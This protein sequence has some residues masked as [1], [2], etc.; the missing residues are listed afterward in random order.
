MSTALDASSPT[1]HLIYGPTAAGKST[2]ARQLAAKVNGVRFAIDDWMH[3]LFGPDLP[4]RPDMAWVMSRVARCQ[5]Q[6]W[7]SS[8]QILGTGT[9]VVLELGLL[10]PED[11]ARAQARVE[12]AGHTAQFHFADAP[13]AMRR[14]RVWQR[15]ANKGETY[16]FDITPGMFDAM[17]SIFEPPTA[18]ELAASVRI[19]G[20]TR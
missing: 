1:A 2:Y 5:Q 8:L 16:A 13:L 10:R 11:R 20:V 3:A 12:A 19:E 9:P 6:I 18:Q 7:S 4:E 17:E 14:Q 15:N